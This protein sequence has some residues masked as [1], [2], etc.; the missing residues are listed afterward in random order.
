LRS[1][2]QLKAGLLMALES[3]SVNAEQMARQ[4]LAQD[5]FVAISELIAEVEAVDHDRIKDFAAR[6]RGEAAS[7]V[8]IGS[9]KKSAAQ[10]TRV[11]ALFNP[12]GADTMISQGSR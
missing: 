8:V 5:R 4:L 7:V 6:L 9:G 2:A 10:A 11:A 3:S 1:K 12:A